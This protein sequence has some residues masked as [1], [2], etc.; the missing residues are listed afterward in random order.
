MAFLIVGLLGLFLVGCL[1]YG[2]YSGVGAIVR[3]ASRAPAKRR[4]PLSSAPAPPAAAPRIS[5]PA[6]PPDMAPA[7]VFA[8]S[9]DAG[10]NSGANPSSASRA[11]SASSVT[12]ATGEL[13][14]L[15]ELHQ[16]GALTPEEFAQMKQHLLSALAEKSSTSKEMP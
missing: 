11:S 8:Q 3:G 9:H 12:S 4:E 7:Q 5:A 16:S 6:A 13:K 1:L 10:V 14:A 2:I 15:F